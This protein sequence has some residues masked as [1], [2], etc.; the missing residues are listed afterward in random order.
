MSSAKRYL[1]GSLLVATM[2]GLS[3]ASWAAESEVK[4]LQVKPAVV[5][6]L[7]TELTQQVA[8]QQL[9]QMS[10]LQLEL[11]AT[12]S[13]LINTDRR[14]ADSVQQVAVAD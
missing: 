4:Q 7:K 9:Q 11:Q 5:Q 8:V 6:D 10:Q 2:I 13:G 12:I 1:V 14:R 3:G